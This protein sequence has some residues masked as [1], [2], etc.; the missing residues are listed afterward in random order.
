MGNAGEER[1]S[2]SWI[3]V[4]IFVARDFAFKDSFSAAWALRSMALMVSMS[5]RLSARSLMV[6]SLKSAAWLYFDSM[7]NL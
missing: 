7:C 5:F 1:R 2:W 6:F 3:G 4:A